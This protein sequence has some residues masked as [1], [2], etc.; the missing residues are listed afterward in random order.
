[1]PGAMGGLSAL[2]YV[3]VGCVLVHSRTLV[4]QAGRLSYVWLRASHREA[5][6]N[7][8]R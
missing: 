5:S 8:I 1:M 2:V 6:T 3:W 4:G 7:S